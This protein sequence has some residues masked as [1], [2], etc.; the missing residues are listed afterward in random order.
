MS[1]QS[2]ELEIEVYYKDARSMVA[3]TAVKLGA[4]VEPNDRAGMVLH[5]EPHGDLFA[6]VSS[7]N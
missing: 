4:L 1:I 2:K 3:F 6:E 5:L 7:T